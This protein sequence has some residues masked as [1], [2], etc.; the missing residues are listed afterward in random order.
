LLD[1][2]GVNI[3]LNNSRSPIEVVAGIGNRYGD[4]VFLL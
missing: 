3:N 2:E 4:I 1:I